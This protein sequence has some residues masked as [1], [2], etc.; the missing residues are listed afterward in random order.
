MS[1]R[2]IGAALLCTTAMVSPSQAKAGPILGFLQGFVYA[3]S[4]GAIGVAGIGGAGFLAGATAG[5]YATRTIAGQLLLS[6]GLSAVSQYLTRR[7]AA[8]PSER[9]A[10][11]SQPISYAETAY[12]RLRKGGPLGFTGFARGDDVV[13]GKSG[14]KRHYSP[15][16]AMHSCKGVVEHWLGDRV[17]Q[18]DADGTVTTD[19][20][21]DHY[22]IRFFTGQAGQAADPDLVARFAEITAAHDFVGLTGA[23]IWARRASDS[24]FSDV[25]PDGREAA[26]A[27]VFDGHDQV[28]DPRDTTYK[29]TR[30]A[31]LII[32][33]WLTTIIGAQVDWSEVAAEADVADQT[34]TIKGGGTRARWTI[35]GA[36]S[37]DQDFEDQRAQFM[38]AADAWMY[39]RP[40]GKV[41]F[42]LG[43][44]EAP[45]LT[46]TERDFLSLE[47]SS[48]S[49]QG[50]P[51]SIAV[52]YTEPANDYKES[53]TADLTWDPA[54]AETREEPEAYLITEHNQ[55]FRVQRRL[56]ALKHPE[57]SLRGTVGMIGYRL[58]GRRFVT[59]DHAIYGTGHYEIQRL[60]RNA[61]GFTFDFDAVE[62]EAGDFDPD[63]SA[64]EPDRPAYQRV[65][66][67]DTV[68][69]LAGLT[70]Q[71]R[72][73]GEILYTWTDPG[74][75]NLLQRLRLRR[76][77]ETDWQQYDVPSGQQSFRARGLLDGEDYEAQGVNRTPAQRQSQTWQP[78]TPIVTRAV[79]N[80]TPPVA[81][82]SFSASASGAD[83]VLSFTAPNDGNYY[84]T[85]IYRA[86]GGGAAFSAATLVR[87]EFGIPSNAD[88]WTDSAPGSGTWRYWIVPINQSGLPADDGT[89]P[90][91]A[92]GPVNVTLP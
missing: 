25:Y 90:A 55:A 49:A 89:L 29:W 75:D 10:N 50:A 3:A 74:D 53:V 38:A 19:P 39:E 17:V 63:V 58:I 4:A 6:V 67:D 36:I 88:S 59:V 12:G 45:S 92:S 20:P 24:D 35:D 65:V 9:F 5:Y 85:R 18:V 21:G 62:V 56:L 26:Y 30:N 91:T 86:S 51:N 68:P 72:P 16:L 15:V 37:D 60:A 78:P 87:T 27:P 73:G 46:L 23:H 81:H 22:R 61:D 57:S 28:Y 43:R 8:P 31:A 47:R 33:H 70:G 69:D 40:D 83:A 77:G 82:T 52:R 76:S 14:S 1:A 66:S 32:A 34:V 11:F 54:A 41:G 48:G 7:R 64:I 44:W 79:A 80:A 84:A 2:L 13:T 42:R 71:A